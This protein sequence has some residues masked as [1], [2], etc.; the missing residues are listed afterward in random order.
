MIHSFLDFLRSLTNPERLIE[1]LGTLLTG[2]L[3]YA[4]LFLLVFAETGM[5]VGS[6]CRATRCCSR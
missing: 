5:L 2:W 1:L 6:S 4:T 3:G